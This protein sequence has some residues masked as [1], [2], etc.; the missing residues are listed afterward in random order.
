MSSGRIK[1]DGK[2]INWIWKNETILEL[3]VDQIIAVGEL[4][5]NALDEDYFVILVTYDGKWHRVSMY[6]EEIDQLLCLLAAKFG[7][8]K[9]EAQLANKT[10]FA[11]AITYPS[12]LKG[13]LIVEKNTQNQIELSAPIQILI[14][15]GQ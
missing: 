4:T 14:Q 3:P 13:E 10:D 2:T 1:I 6:A 15:S 8:K 5:L 12:A 7:V 9:F 11:S